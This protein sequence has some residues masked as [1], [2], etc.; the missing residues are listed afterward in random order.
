MIQIALAMQLGVAAISADARVDLHLGGSDYKCPAPLDGEI[1]V[2]APNAFADR[3]RVP[4]ARPD[5][6]PRD[7]GDERKS[8]LGPDYR[9]AAVSVSGA[10]GCNHSINIII[11]RF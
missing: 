9:C 6:S 5:M 4:A 8:L 11:I 3:Y 1:V 2:C 10:A 7:L